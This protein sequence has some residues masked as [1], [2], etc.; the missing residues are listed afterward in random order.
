MALSLLLGISPDVA[1]GCS[2]PFNP[3]I[4]ALGPGQLVVVGRVGE[5]VDGGRL[6][7]VVR[8]FNGDNPRTPIVIAFKEGEPVGDCSYPVVAGEQKLIAPTV[9]E[10]GTLYADLATLQADPTSPEGQRYLAEAVALFG[11]G[12]VP[13]GVAAPPD[14]GPSW[15]QPITIAVVIAAGAALLVGI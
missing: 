14:P 15:L 5:R 9:Q 13:V 12:V 1:L 2:P 7:H 11:P 3:T 4:E 10:D 6:F 8:W